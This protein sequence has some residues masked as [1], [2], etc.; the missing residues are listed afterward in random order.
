M[1]YETHWEFLKNSALLG[2][3]SHAYVFSGN[4]ETGQLRLALKLSQLL[5]CESRK[6]GE[7]CQVCASC[8]GITERTHPDAVWIAETREIPIGAIRELR[9]HFSLSS[10]QSS[11]KI[12]VIEKA[13]VMNIEAQSA[14]LKLLEEP[15]QNAILFLCT[16]HPDLLLDT[17]RS[18]AQ[19]IRWYV[20]P[21]VLKGNS[22]NVEDLKRL[23]GSLLQERFDYAKKAA[24]TPEDAVR[25]LE[26]WMRT[27]RSILLKTVSDSSE[28]IMQE[29]RVLKTMQ[30][31]LQ[32]IQTTNVTPRL[33]IEQVLVEL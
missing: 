11:F 14:L 16:K 20:F 1:R 21:A 27:Q 28:N 30:E 18:R 10:W 23:K 7:P 24:E 5:N 29:E 3:L 9:H 22:K 8:R 17:I 2:K 26:E 31:M 15:R 19:E 32:V 33:A 6:G 13:H 12:A 4:D 25:I